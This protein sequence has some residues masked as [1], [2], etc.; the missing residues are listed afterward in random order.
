MPPRN[1]K[2][3]CGVGIND[4]DYK[5][6]PKIK[7]NGKWKDLPPCPYY[8]KWVSMLERCYSKRHQRNAQTYVGC[9]VCDEWLYFSKFRKWMEQ[10]DWQGRALDKD[11]ISEGNK[12]YSPETCVFLPQKLNGFII[13]SKKSKSLYPLGVSYKKKSKDMQSEYSRPYISEI[14]T[15]DRKGRFIGHFASPEDAHNA[16][17]REKLKRCTEYIKEF[18]DESLIIKGLTRIKDKIEYHIENNL[19]LTSF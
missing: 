12:V 4:V 2:P 14:N 8:R 11:F 5:V 6:K 3:V 17:L 15:L 16:Y 9:T 13:I 18:R 19:E 7:V 10:Q 1:Y